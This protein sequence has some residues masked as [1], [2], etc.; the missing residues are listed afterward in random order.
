MSV[1]ASPS[2]PPCGPA[3]CRRLRGVPA[4]LLRVAARQLAPAHRGR[5]QGYL[6][7][8]TWIPMASKQA[9]NRDQ[10]WGVS[11]SIPLCAWC[12]TL[13]CSCF[14][15]HMWRHLRDLFYRKEALNLV[16]LLCKSRIGSRL[17][18]CTFPS[19]IFLKQ[20]VHGVWCLKAKPL[21]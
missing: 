9:T 5:S 16:H 10:A 18:R 21:Y 14:V 13:L 11:T 7:V 17:W 12:I 1:V 2:A 8:F 19:R 3:P 15:L 20:V 4:A 6:C